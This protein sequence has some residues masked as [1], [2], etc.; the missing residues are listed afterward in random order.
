MS[1]R[2]QIAAGRGTPGAT[3]A[4]HAAAPDSRATRS[5]VFPSLAEI[6]EP[7][8]PFLL[9]LVLLLAARAAFWAII[10]YATEDAYITFRYARNLASGLGLAYNPG[11]HVM[12]FSSPLWVIWNAAGYALTRDPLLWS[13]ASCLLADLVTLILMGGLIKRSSSKAAAFCF[14]FFFAAWPYFSAISV[15]GMEMS[16]LL[17]LMVL[18]AALVESD[19]PASGPA[20]AALALARPEG[21]AAAVVLGLGARWRD[22]AI[23]AAL[24]AVGIGALGAYFGSVVPQSV[25]AKSRLYGTPG[26]WAGR[27]WWEWLSP[28][29]LGRWPR[30]GETSHLEILT[31]VVAP[32]FVLGAAELW[33]R[34]AF[35]LARAIGAPLVVWLGYSLLG[36][37]Y[38]WWYLAVPLAGIVAL[39]SLGFPRL[40]HGRGLPIACVL[41]VLG[42]WTIVPKLY[43]ARG[44]EESLSFGRAADVLFRNGRP[45]E[46]VMLEP[47]GIVGYLTP[48]IVI[49]EVGLVSPR[50]AARRLQGPGW[51]ADVVASERP[52]WLVV[53]AGVLRT[54]EAFAGAGALFRSSAERESL[55]ARYRVVDTGP[56]QF[57]DATLSVLRRE[58]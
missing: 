9:P 34:R 26:P 55:F 37:A 23:A 30:P 40:V 58:R 38:F 8:G 4:P 14:T 10:P 15:S 17:A 54:G 36:V 12:G 43:T 44:N 41:M 21:I 20:L 24:I 53:R 25:I 19:S 3:Q 48:L 47:I 16:A 6:L 22:R 39:G 13:R 31:V 57:K 33:K 27:H 7:R 51:Y 1:R 11:E 52:D 35:G 45:G 42:I 5:P 18:A 28:F 32:S 29:V 56:P 50:V 46:K 2:K 49:D